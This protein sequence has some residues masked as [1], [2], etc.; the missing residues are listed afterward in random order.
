MKSFYRMLVA[1]WMIL[2]TLALAVTVG[3]SAVQTLE[4]AA[5]GRPWVETLV[6]AIVLG[7]LIRSLWSPARVWIP[8]IN[9]GAKTLLELAVMRLGASISVQKMLQIRPA[10]TACIALVVIGSLGCCYGIGQVLGL[11]KRVSLLVHAGIRF[12]AIPQ[13]P[14][15]AP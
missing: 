8:G 11:S 15:W 10:L 3:A 4:I 9:C 13:S 5:F 6:L 14:P 1:A 2:P 12:V 7:A